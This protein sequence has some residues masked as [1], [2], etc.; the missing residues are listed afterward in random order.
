L[1]FA[2]SCVALRLPAGRAAEARFYLWDFVFL[3]RRLVLC[4]CAVVFKGSPHI[5]AV[6]P[7]YS[8]STDEYPGTAVGIT[9]TPPPWIH[10][11]GACPYMVQRGS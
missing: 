7:E 8:F 1:L 6:R 2:W 10:S 4:L 11:G 5:Q 9:S 3:M